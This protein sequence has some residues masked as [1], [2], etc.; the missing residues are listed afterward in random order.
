MQASTGRNSK[1]T[2]NCNARYMTEAVFWA[3]LALTLVVETPIYWL[4]LTCF[5]AVRPRPALLTALGVN[6][7]SYPLFVL[8]LVPGAAAMV[9]PS[10]AVVA[11]EVAVCV[12]EAVLVCWWLRTDAYLAAAASLL[13][14]GCSVLAGL[15]IA[16]FY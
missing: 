8:L 2:A 5:A 9:P 6:L 13:A 7:V 14:N 1:V 15:L 4:L 11:G 12:L 10:A 3:F 16:V